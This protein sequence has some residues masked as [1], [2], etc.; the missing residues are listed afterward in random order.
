MGPSSLLPSPP[1]RARPCPIG[2]T[3]LPAARRAGWVQG[4]AEGRRTAFLEK[5]N[6]NDKDNDNTSFTASLLYASLCFA[7]ITTTVPEQVRT[8]F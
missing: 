3:P 4:D 8:P 2:G 6:A 7:R 1:P 5:N